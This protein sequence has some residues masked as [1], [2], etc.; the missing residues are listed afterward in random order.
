MK[1]VESPVFTQDR[2]HH[3]PTS[4]VH[5]SNKCVRAR[6]G[7]R[8][9]DNTGTPKGL[10]GEAKSGFAKVEPEEVSRRETHVVTRTPIG[11]SG[12]N[13]R[14]S[15]SKGTTVATCCDR[16]APHACPKRHATCTG[17]RR[18]STNGAGGRSR[19]FACPNNVQVACCRVGPQR[20]GQRRNFGSQQAAGDRRLEPQRGLRQVVVPTR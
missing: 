15:H 9:H 8:G 7:H 10:S 4:S 13:A 12:L 6:R 20:T 2:V 18:V 14:R 3:V 19:A 16:K 17:S 1:A 5:E 11:G